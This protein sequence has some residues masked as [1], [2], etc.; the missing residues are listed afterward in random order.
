ML[1]FHNHCFMNDV[2]TSKIYKITNQL[3]YHHSLDFKKLHF[4]SVIL[5]RSIT[6]CVP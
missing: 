5:R 1:C 2:A 3:K 4:N 6:Y